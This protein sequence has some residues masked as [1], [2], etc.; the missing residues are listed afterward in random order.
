MVLSNDMG[1][2]LS[3]HST[4]LVVPAVLLSCAQAA[5]KRARPEP[6]RLQGE[7]ALPRAMD[8]PKILTRQL[9]CIA[10]KSA[11]PLTPPRTGDERPQIPAYHS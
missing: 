1:F 4:R 8:D 2:L 11:A 7:L 5:L 9:A 6:R 10:M 3:G